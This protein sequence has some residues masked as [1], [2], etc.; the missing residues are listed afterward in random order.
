MLACCAARPPRP[1][2][3]QPDSTPP[4]LELELQPEL[5][6]EPELQPEPEQEQVGQNSAGD[7]GI[8]TIESIMALH[9]LT[10]E[11]RLRC[12]ELRQRLPPGA[13]DGLPTSEMVVR[14]L[15]ATRFQ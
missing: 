8:E 15:R 14:F 6:L 2:Q 1:S 11:Q 13:D 7:E 9:D 5:K 12:L 4:Q 10:Q 3:R